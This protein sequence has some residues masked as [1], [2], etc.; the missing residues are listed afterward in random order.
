M[1]NRN[2]ARREVPDLVRS[3]TAPPEPMRAEG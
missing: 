1:P 2:D 3:V